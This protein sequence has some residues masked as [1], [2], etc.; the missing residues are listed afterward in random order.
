MAREFKD[1]SVLGA[2]DTI[3]WWDKA[4]RLWSK[5]RAYEKRLLGEGKVAQAARWGAVLA[6]LTAAMSRAV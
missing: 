5:V 2:T 6:A 4:G 1:N 3:E